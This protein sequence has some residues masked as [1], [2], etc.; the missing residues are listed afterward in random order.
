M[1]KVLI[2]QEAPLV[3]ILA[4]EENI[5]TNFWFDIPKVTNDN[6][7]YSNKLYSKILDASSFKLNWIL[8]PF[9]RTGDVGVASKGVGRRFIGFEANKDKLLMSMK[10]I[11]QNNE[12]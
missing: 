12:R 5:Q 2:L 3:Q 6:A 8:D 4:N 7:R 9:M 1:I 11:D 10:R